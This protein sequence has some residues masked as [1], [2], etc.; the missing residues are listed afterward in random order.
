[1]SSR[2]LGPVFLVA[3]LLLAPPAWSQPAS[4]PASTTV[5]DA[6][7][8]ATLRAVRLAA[9][10][11]IDGKLDEPV[12]R[13]VLPTS[14]F[15][16][17]DPKPGAPAS[18]NTDVWVFF[19]GDAIYFTLRVWEDHPD[20][21]ITNDMKRDALTLA[22]GELITLAFD[23]FHDRRSAYYFSINP[24]G[25]FSE[26]QIFNESQVSVD[27]NG[28][29]RFKPGRF[30]GGWT[31]E[32][33]IPFK[34]L[35]YP[36]S[37]PQTWGLQVQR[38]NRWKNEV[39]VVTPT[40]PQRLSAAFLL[41]S[42]FGDLVGLEP[43]APGL[44]L[45]VKPYAIANVVTDRAVTP[46]RV[47]DAT[48]NVGLDVKYAITPGM[49]ADFTYKTDFAQVEVDEQQVNLT[50]FNLFFPEKREFFLENS[51]TFSFGGT[52]AGAQG[53]AGDAPVLFYSRSIGLNGTA[54]VPV[55]TGGRVT[56]RVGRFSLG[57]LDIQTDDEPVSRA[58][59]TNFSVIR[60]KRDILR[61]SAIGVLA[62]NRSVSQRAP[63]SNQTYGADATL[64]FFTNLNLN[65]YWA[66]TATSGR[67]TGDTSYRAQLDYAADRWGAQVE[68]LKIG[69]NF[70]PEMGFVRRLNM[71]KNYALGRFS[72]RTRG[73]PVV[74][75]FTYI[76]TASLIENTAGRLE[77]RALTGEFTIDFQNSDKFTA[78]YTGSYEFL[79]APFRLAPA[80]TL[81][82]GGYDFHTA[83]GAYT[84]GTHR[85][86][87]G[88]M[89]V[90]RGSFY[91]GDRTTVTVSGA[92]VQIRPQFFIEPSAS[93]NH[94]DLRQGSFS[95]N[96]VGARLTYSMTS[97]R[98][99][100]ALLQW[101]SAARSF[102]SNVRMR[103]EYRPG[104]E[105]FV[106]YNDTRDTTPAGWPVLL[107]RS[108]IVKI[109]RLFRF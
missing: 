51:G 21:M 44:N 84:F 56:G 30:D 4:E 1:M 32:M 19:D 46:R 101:N 97:Y 15:T 87:S 65:T 95:T 36:G 67:T 39:S 28:I 66:R 88:K 41:V 79:P 80:V 83:A 71:R 76:G 35:R 23:T 62:S 93:F 73:N 81:P 69:A 24:I 82:V 47:N 3:S 2:T 57:L 33:A 40:E 22:N 74:R 26:G 34:T 11:S 78:L 64:G 49:A 96:L 42:R 55:R 16:Q 61:K 91:N 18:Q 106:V 52:V 12:Y 103:W 92:R 77:S 17:L 54:Q 85:R 53:V 89:N 43:P 6:S 63:G 10:L 13:E 75:R 94:V 5:R 37:G 68:H 14:G 86:V 108:F 109:N 45:D 90:E 99:V 7:G 104:S 72:P 31:F 70:N 8:R 25:G 59:S 98:F 107:N 58:R 29:W 48:A 50:R 102:A 105:L 20:K 27:W 38:V 100:S 9:P 60:V